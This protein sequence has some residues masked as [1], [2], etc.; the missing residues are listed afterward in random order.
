MARY[1]DLPIQRITVISLISVAVTV[2]SILA[3]QVLYFGMSRYVNENKR[4]A[5]SYAESEEYLARQTRAISQFAVHEDDGNYVI[6]IE[7]AMRKIV[8][9]ASDKNENQSATTNEA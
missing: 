8:R 2:V 4:A 7:Q 1:D 6:P 5:S 3:V 9:Q